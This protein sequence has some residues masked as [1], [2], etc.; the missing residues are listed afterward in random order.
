MARKLKPFVITLDILMPRRDGWSV[1][2]ELKKDPELRAIPVFILSIMENRALGFSL[3]VSDYIVKPFD[4][5]ELLDDRR[6]H[7]RRAEV[8]P[9][10]R[11]EP[12]NAV[13]PGAHPDRL[14]VVDRQ[15]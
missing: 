5:Q 6:G 4:R 1:L 9:A 10:R 2:Q 3:G 14:P 8:P 13:A 11:V 15:R 12:G 7:R